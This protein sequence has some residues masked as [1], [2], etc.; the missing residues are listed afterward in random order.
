MAT[1][2]AAP[3]T[4]DQLIGVVVSHNPEADALGHLRDAVLVGRLLDEQADQLIGHFVDEAR[5]AGASWTSI[6]DS[7]GVSKQ[8]AQQRFVLTDDDVDGFRNRL[9]GRF[10]PRA[11]QAVQ[12][13]RDEAQRLAADR[14]EPAH[15]V[16]GLLSETEGIAARAL[17][18]QGIGLDEAEARFEAP[19]APAKKPPAFSNE[20]KRAMQL[21]LREALKRGHNYIGT[22]HLLLGVLAAG[23]GSGVELLVALGVDAAA[24]E[25]S[26]E[27]LLAASMPAKQRRRGR[28]S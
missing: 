27:E 8:A 4:L 10:T 7:L 18:A 1:D 25:A 26:I 20:A 21:A 5:Q 2:P 19:E 15:L 22:E 3:V 16:L 9:F 13:A 17:A 11:R 14:V 6:G 24:A 28:R 12:A 23:E